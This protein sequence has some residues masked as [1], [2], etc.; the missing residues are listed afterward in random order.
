MKN[1]EFTKQF[2]IQ[3]APTLNEH[4]YAVSKLTKKGAEKKLGYYPSSTTILN[5]YPQAAHLNKWIGEN[6]WNESQRILKEAGLRGTK[7]HDAVERLLDGDELWNHHFSLDEWHRIDAFVRWFQATKPEILAVEVALFSPKHG[8]AGRVDCVCIIDGK[9]TVI[10][11]KTSGAMYP[12][13]P[14]QFA[15]YAQAIEE[16][17]SLKV[18]Q[19][20]GLQL[21][22]KSKAGY[23]FEVHEGWRMDFEMFKTVKQIWEYDR[24]GSKKT[25]KQMEAPVLILPDK[26]SLLNELQ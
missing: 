26:L 24:F 13:F 3:L 12:H 11:W 14:L 25:K 22:T 5:A 15:S 6:G 9:V 16:T 2:V 21:G 18:D 23:K 4:W 1:L 7:V 8:Y 19:T 20:A 10:D 17:T